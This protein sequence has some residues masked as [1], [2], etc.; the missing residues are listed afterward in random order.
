MNLADKLRNAK[1]LID[2]PCSIQIT[3][4]RNPDAVTR[5]AIRARD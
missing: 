1:D 5:Q 4:Q 2:S 3:Y